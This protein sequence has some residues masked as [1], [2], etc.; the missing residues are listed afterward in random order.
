MKM[1]IENELKENKIVL[2]LVP[3]LDYNDIVH[4][5]AKIL[6]KKNLGYITLNKTA[7]SLKEDFKKAKVNVENIL[8]IDAIS[9]TIKNVPDQAKGDRKSTR[10][11]SSH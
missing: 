11:N 2:L 1:D 10:L 5:N 3:S 9:K 7:D 4:A 8:F 6:S